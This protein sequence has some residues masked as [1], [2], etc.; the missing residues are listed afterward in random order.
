MF[1]FWE[2]KIHI[3]HTYT[4]IH[5]IFAKQELLLQMSPKMQGNNSNKY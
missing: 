3:P 1:F 2:E 5:T 4:Y